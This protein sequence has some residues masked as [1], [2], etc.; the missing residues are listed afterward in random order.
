MSLL[1]QTQSS[2]ELKAM[3][4]LPRQIADLERAQFGAKTRNY[5]GLGVLRFVQRRINIDAHHYVFH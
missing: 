1:G 3:S 4:A 5:R 2:N